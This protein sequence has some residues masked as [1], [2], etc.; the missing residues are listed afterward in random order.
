MIAGWFIL[1]SDSKAATE[2]RRI[3]HIEATIASL[4]SNLVALQIA[5]GSEDAEDSQSRG[6]GYRAQYYKDGAGTMEAVAVQGGNI[7][8]D[9][10]RGAG[11][12]AVIMPDVANKD[13]L[14]VISATSNNN[15]T[16]TGYDNTSGEVFN[17]W[18]FKFDSDYTDY[19]DIHQ[20]GGSGWVRFQGVGALRF[21]SVTNYVTITND[22]LDADSIDVNHIRVNTTAYCKSIDI[23][24]IKTDSLI[25]G[26]YHFVPGSYTIPVGA[27]ADTN[28]FSTAAHTLWITYES[29]GVIEINDKFIIKAA[30]DFSIAG[31]VSF[32]GTI[33]DA[34][35]IGYIHKRGAVKTKLPGAQ[36]SDIKTT[37]RS[38]P[39]PVPGYLE[40]GAINDT[41]Y[42]YVKNSGA[43]NITARSGYIEITYRHD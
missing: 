20:S 14:L 33:N 34:I 10:I 43:G 30:G 12:S 24:L 16:F 25:H 5:I 8:T 18:R 19:L 6:L 21:G 29:D 35:E 32:S 7:E 3:L 42:M 28:I 37:G 4:S 26:V 11:G 2:T 31:A 38:S 36:I 22:A 41:I 27:A 13:E 39:T 1:F 9:T 17:K 15:I 40:D 23:G